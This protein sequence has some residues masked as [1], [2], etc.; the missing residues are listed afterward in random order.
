MGKR[1]SGSIAL[2][3]ILGLS[4]VVISTFTLITRP[5]CQ[6]PCSDSPGLKHTWSSYDTTEVITSIIYSRVED[7][8]LTITLH[9]GE[10]IYISFNCYAYSSGPDSTAGV[11]F[12]VNGTVS[13][14]YTVIDLIGSGV[15]Y[16]ITLQGI[17]KDEDPGNYLVSVI[18]GRSGSDCTY[19][20]LSL[21]VQTVKN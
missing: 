5:T 13:Y 10:W 7:L 1:F 21:I 3:I 4:G 20:S 11:R 19:A 15:M 17:V 6:T 18:A 12:Y 14:P 2:A 8:D 9:E 16:G